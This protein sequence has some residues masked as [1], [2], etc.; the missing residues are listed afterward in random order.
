[1]FEARR[2]TLVEAVLK[3]GGPTLERVRGK[4]AF[5]M[6]QENV[7]P[8]CIEGH[9]SLRGRMVFTNAKPEAPDAAFVQSQQSDCA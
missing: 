7:T 2:D 8:L 4:V 5:V 3:D 6:D 1:M 9:P